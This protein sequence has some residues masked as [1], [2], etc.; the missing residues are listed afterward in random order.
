[1]N[2]EIR[3]LELE[4]DALMRTWK[5]LPPEVDDRWRS[6]AGNEDLW[7]RVSGWLSRRVP[8]HRDKR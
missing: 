8:W 5:P 2:D 3:Q 4:R 7:R 1:M 6:S